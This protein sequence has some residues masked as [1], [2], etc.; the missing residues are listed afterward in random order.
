MP[1]CP[2]H[3]SL[4][5]SGPCT[6]VSC[7]NHVPALDFKCLMLHSGIYNRDQADIL[8]SLY[9]KA[10]KMTVALAIKATRVAYAVK[11]LSPSPGRHLVGYEKE[12]VSSIIDAGPLDPNLTW[13][14]LT[15]GNANMKLAE[16]MRQV[17]NTME[18]HEFSLADVLE[19]YQIIF[20]NLDYSA[21]AIGAEDVE[22]VEE[23]LRR[24][25]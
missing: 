5:L 9:G 2:V 1:S 7:Y 4:N 21:F 16:R 15:A 20:H 14:D 8:H 23:L 17:L 19:S 24:A 3:K 6:N 11:G 25:S 10:Y 12:W 18:I 22:D 13:P